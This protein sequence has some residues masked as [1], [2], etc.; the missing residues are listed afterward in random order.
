MSAMTEMPAKTPSPIGSTESCLPGSANAA[1]A[2]VLALGVVS[3]WLAAAAVA[4]AE[5]VTLAEPVA[6]AEPVVLAVPVALA[7]PVVACAA[8][9]AGMKDEPYER[10]QQCAARSGAGLTITT[11]AGGVEEVVALVELP[12]VSGTGDALVV[13]ALAVA[14]AES[15]LLADDV[16]AVSEPLDDDAAGLALVVA[17][18]V[19]ELVVDAAAVSELLFAGAGALLTFG[20]GW[21]GVAGVVP[22][23]TAQDFA[24]RNAG[25]P[26]SPVIGV[27]VIVQTSVT[28]VPSLCAC[29]ARQRGY[30]L[31]GGAPGRTRCRYPSSSD[32][33][34]HRSRRLRRA[35]R[36]RR[37]RR[38]P[39][40]ARAWYAGRA[41]HG[42]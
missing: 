12:F 5:L 21:P 8:A 26:S 29:A 27:S 3:A 35:Y 9:E 7:V 28:C 4:P 18:V 39:R 42:Q 19:S 16:A 37:P 22:I 25:W 14:E 1:A 20:A 30:C 24:I 2:V 10:R 13:E 17:A 41:R 34:P 33:R 36:V 38:G 23:V 15:V 6:L 11:A 32:S 31:C 40:R